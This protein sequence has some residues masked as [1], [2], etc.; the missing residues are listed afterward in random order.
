MFS[1]SFNETF[2]SLTG[3]FT[4]QAQVWTHHLESFILLLFSSLIQTF[5]LQALERHSYVTEWR[6]QL[7]VMV[8]TLCVWW[9]DW[10]E[11]RETLFPVVF[12]F[13]RHVTPLHACA[14][15]I[16]PRTALKQHMFPPV[17]S[18][19]RRSL[20]S[21]TCK[22]I[23]FISHLWMSV[24]YICVKVTFKICFMRR[25]KHAAALR[26]PESEQVFLSF[27]W[28]KSVLLDSMWDAFTWQV[29]ENV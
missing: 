5:S 3:S 26:K 14:E 24:F 10:H 15:K 7:V 19:V 22:N 21:Y 16:C 9:L 20:T 1:A 23:T 6:R 27:V 8:M 12:Q 18:D 11:C 4:A 28:K 25:L 13:V 2:H 29:K 17:K